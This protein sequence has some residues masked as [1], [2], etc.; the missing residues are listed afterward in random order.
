MGTERTWETHVQRNDSAAGTLLRDRYEILRL[1]GEGGFASTYQALDHQTNQ[2][3]VIKELSWNKVEDWKFIELF[4]REARVL[5]NLNHPQ[6]PRF[7]E[8]FTEPSDTGSRIFLVQEFIDGQNLRDVVQDGKHFTEKE[9]IEIAL[10]VTK[11]LEYLHSLSPPIIHRDIKP[12]NIMIDSQG[13]VHLVDFGAVRD[14][15]LH[16]Q[17]TAAGGFTVVGTYGFMPFEQFQGRATAASDIYSLGASLLYLLSHKE[18][19]EI[20][21]ID[22]KLELEHHINVSKEFMAVLRKMLEY[23]SADR[24]QSASELSADLRAILEGRTP[25]VAQSKTVVQTKTGSL[26][27]QLVGMGFGLLVIIIVFAVV[28]GKSSVSEIQPVVTPKSEPT[29]SA[30]VVPGIAD[31]HGS[32]FYDGKPIQ[33]FSNVPPRFWFRNED[34]GKAVTAEVEYKNGTFRF[35]G[36]EPGSY[37][38]QTTIDHSMNNPS[39][40]PGDFYSWTP[41]TVREKNS[42]QLRIHMQRVIQMTAPESNA[43][44]MPN[45]TID[46]AKMTVLNSGDLKIRWESI[47]KNIYYDY[48]ISRLTADHKFQGYA[49][50]GTT[51]ATE[52]IVNLP[53]ISEN[54]YYLLTI[55]ARK[56]GRTVGLLMTHGSGGM[57]WDYRFRTK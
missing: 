25:N 43:G 6:I 23:N 19:H 17:K 48:N 42:P 29:I 31:V 7:I 36:L 54:E 2:H 27:Q 20:E 3:C 56:D 47:G 11:I 49:A 1:L 46:A 13:E 40:Y 53:Q 9:I 14:K 5:S 22:S 39:M 52:I 18:P 41:F 26:T 12:S 21:S 32:L 50:S 24:Y 30:P 45:W 37:G 15:V 55:H 57:G 4:E 34:T 51:V 16:S 28:F 33:L 35:I 8:F 44:N 38:V 10:Q